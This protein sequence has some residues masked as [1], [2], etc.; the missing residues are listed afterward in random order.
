M[1]LKETKKVAENRYE[2]EILIDAEKFGEAI[3]TAYKQNAK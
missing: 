2:L 1:S 3:K